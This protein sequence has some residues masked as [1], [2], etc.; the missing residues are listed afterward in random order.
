M[1]ILNVRFQLVILPSSLK[2]DLFSTFVEISFEL[3]ILCRN[4][5]HSKIIST[6]DWQALS[7]KAAEP[8][9]E[10]YVREAEM[11][12]ATMRNQEIETG[13]S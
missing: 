12:L 2:S 4:I 3:G 7:R 10:N 9:T 8:I 11:R 5:L 6:A 1:S 13:T